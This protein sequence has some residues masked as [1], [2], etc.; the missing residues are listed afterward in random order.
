MKMRAE[1]SIE[2]PNDGS[3]A[4]VIRLGDPNE[5]LDFLDRVKWAVT[6]LSDR[7]FTSQEVIPE[8]VVEFPAESVVWPI[9]GNPSVNVICNWKEEE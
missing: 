3:L 8:I 5:A 1:V 7:A 4:G 2:G 6:L 9:S